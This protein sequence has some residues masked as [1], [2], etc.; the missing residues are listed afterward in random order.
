MNA[1]NLSTL[2]RIQLE[3]KESIQREKELKNGLTQSN[4]PSLNI[5]EFPMEKIISTADTKSGSNGFRKFTQNHSSNKGLM[6]K[7]L[8][9]RGK[10][11]MTSLNNSNNQS[12]WSSDAAFKPAKIQVAKGGKSLRNGFVSAE[13]KM[14]K[15]LQEFQQRESQLREERKKSQPNLMAALQLEQENEFESFG[16]GMGGGLKATK[17]MANLYNNSDDGFEDNSSS[18]GGSLK[19]ARSLAELCD[20]SDDESGLPGTHSLILQFENMQFKNRP[21]SQSSRGSSRDY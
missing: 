15:E 8:K 3:I 9:S 11:G 16:Y 19:P 2:D 7:F 1:M 6:H 17:S 12:N 10:V 4:P 13:E 20:V 21:S 5:N 14:K 18:A